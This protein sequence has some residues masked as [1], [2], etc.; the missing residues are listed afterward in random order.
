MEHRVD[1]ETLGSLDGHLGLGKLAMALSFHFFS[2]RSC[3]PAMESS[4]SAIT[5]LSIAN[6]EAVSA[7]V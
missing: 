4:P 3:P 6:R 7:Y 2:N 1:S 5:V